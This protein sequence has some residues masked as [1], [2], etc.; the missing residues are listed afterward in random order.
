MNAHLPILQTI[1]IG[2]VDV[3]RIA[4][5]GQ[6]IVTMAQVDE[7]HQR[8]E[9]TARRTFNENRN[10]FEEGVDFYSLTSDEIRTM[11]QLG[12]FPARTARANVLTERGYLKLTKPMNDDRAWKVQ[13]EMVDVYFAARNDAPHVA[14]L[15][16]PQKLKAVGDVMQGFSRLAGLL[17]LKGNQRALSAAMATHRETG[18]NVLELTGVTHLKSPLA[19]QYVNSTSVGERITPTKTANEVNL[20][21]ETLG[22]QVAHRVP[23]KRPGKKRI[24]YWDLTDAGRKVGGDIFDTGKKDFHGRPVKQVMWPTSVIALVQKH[25]GEAA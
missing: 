5:R 2:G 17:G 18:V 7:I 20:L 16:L 21:L 19:E 6:P 4:Y 23:G 12:I 3:K 11:S 8:P 10:R 22:L 24:A 15:P 14:S 25:L 13:G 9:D 1:S